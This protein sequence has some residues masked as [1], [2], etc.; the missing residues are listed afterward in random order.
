MRHTKSIKVLQHA[1]FCHVCNRS[2]CIIS[3]E[4]EMAEELKILRFSFYLIRLLTSYQKH[5]DVILPGLWEAR[6]PPKAAAAIIRLHT[7]VMRRLSHCVLVITM[8]SAEV[9]SSWYLRVN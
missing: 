2:L 5:F 4:A 1:L 3:V 6:T 7:R 9:F 8:I